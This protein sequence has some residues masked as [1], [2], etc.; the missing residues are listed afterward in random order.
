[1]KEDL[2]KVQEILSHSNPELIESDIKSIDETCFTRMGRRKEP[3]ENQRPRPVKLT[4]KNQKTKY[5]ILKNSHKMK[6]FEK[7]EHIGFKMDLTKKQQLE[8][9]NLRKALEERKKTEDVVIYKKQI[10]LRTEYESLKKQE[11]EKQEQEKKNS[12]AKKDDHGSQNN[13]Q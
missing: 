13:Q 6:T 12:S 7:Q 10:I 2:K 4:L 9:K 11:Q 1:M 3:S 5:Q 8:E